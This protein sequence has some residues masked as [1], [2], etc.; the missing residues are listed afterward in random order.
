MGS[1]LR[2]DQKH[3][4]QESHN[5]VPFLLVRGNYKVQI[6]D[7]LSADVLDLDTIADRF[8][9]SSSGFT[10]HLVGFFSGVRQRGLQT[11]EELLKEGTVITGIQS[12]YEFFIRILCFY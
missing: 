9:P 11:T 6:F 3:T 2:A 12:K 10:D 8:E 1:V 4:I 5:I 7:P